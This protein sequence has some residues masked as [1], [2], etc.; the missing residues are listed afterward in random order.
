MSLARILQDAHLR[1]DLPLPLDVTLWKAIA[2]SAGASAFLVGGVY[3]E[4]TTLEQ[5]R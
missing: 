3:A 1:I 5:V 4:L 2:Y